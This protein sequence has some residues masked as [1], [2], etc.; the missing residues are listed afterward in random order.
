MLL[1]LLCAS[2]FRFWLNFNGQN[3]QN[4]QNGRNG[5]KKEKFLAF[6]NIIFGQ[7]IVQLVKQVLENER[8][9]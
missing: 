6:A 4:G 8:M 9:P 5:Q 7:L 1:L 3:E 2:N